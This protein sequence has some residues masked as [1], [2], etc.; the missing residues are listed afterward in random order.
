MGIEL[1]D[2]TIMF[3]IKRFK[4]ELQEIINSTKESAMRLNSIVQGKIIKPK[5]AIGRFEYVCERQC[6]KIDELCKSCAC[7][8][9]RSEINM[10]LVEFIARNK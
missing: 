10:M 9:I 4:S 7:R 1:S 3:H 8:Q 6:Q 2:E 5:V